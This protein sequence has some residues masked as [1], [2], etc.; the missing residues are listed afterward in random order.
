M[1][2]DDLQRFYAALSILQQRSGGTQTLAVCSGR[3]KWPQRGVYFFSELGEER[4]HSGSGLRVVR[5]GTH[6]LK[7]HSR[8]RLWNRLSQHRGYSQS[9]SGNHRGSIFRLIVGQ[10][11]IA[12]HGYRF[13]MWGEGS[14]APKEV[15]IAEMPLECE[16]SRVVGAM[17]FLWLAI[18]DEAGPAS[19]RGY[20]ERNSIA[21]LSNFGKEPL[22]APSSTWLGHHCDR[23]RVRGSGLWN[24]DHVDGVYDRNF[25]DILEQLVGKAVGEL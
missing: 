1:R 15:R 7:T 11:L 20:I 9:G 25:L 13:P 23:S 22:D 8:T 2:I 10:S 6:A 21:L 18:D 14:N 5:V 3:M 19:L 16:V 4:S 12:Q 24:S 17:P